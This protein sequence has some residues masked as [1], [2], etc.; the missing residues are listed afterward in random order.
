MPDEPQIWQHSRLVDAAEVKKS[1][2]FTSLP[3][4]ISLYDN[5]ADNTAKDGNRVW[6]WFVGDELD[7]ATSE[8]SSPAG[9]LCSFLYP[10]CAPARVEAMAHI[11]ELL[12][13][14]K[15]LLRLT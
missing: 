13:I 10:E 7:T 8:T 15:G 6:H 3:V 5:V 11:N 4:R 1:G 9:N 2:C 12:L 14:Q